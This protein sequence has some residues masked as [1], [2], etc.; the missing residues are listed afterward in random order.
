MTLIPP[1]RGETLFDKT[2]LPNLRLIRYLEEIATQVNTVE[3]IDLINEAS[4]NTSAP[5]VD[6]L[7]K[8]IDALY[9]QML[10]NNA[11]LSKI[12]HKL[13]DLEVLQ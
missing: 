2:G 9:A 6:K 5:A 12:L 13:N 7:S 3:D 4:I 11:M 1:K 10:Y 8:Q